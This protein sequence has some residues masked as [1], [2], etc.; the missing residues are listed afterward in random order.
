MV[1]AQLLKLLNFQF[2]LLFIY[3]YNSEKLLTRNTL[4]CDQSNYSLRIVLSHIPIEFGQNG[5][6]AIRSADPKNPILERNTQ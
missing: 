5:I 1:S 2:L 3:E 4:D 6:S